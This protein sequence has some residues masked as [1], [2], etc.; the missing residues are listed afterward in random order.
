M[1][2]VKSLKQFRY[3]E[4]TYF[5][6][7]VVEVSPQRAEYLVRTRQGEIVEGDAPKQASKPNKNG[8]GKSRKG[9]K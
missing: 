7:D 3:N 2:K 4:K 9:N 1:K 6:G 8:K 5:P